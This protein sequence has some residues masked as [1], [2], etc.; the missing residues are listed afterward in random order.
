[1]KT[2]DV[3]GINV[4][5]TDDLNGGGVINH[6]DFVIALKKK[7][8]NRVFDNC[9]E[10]CSGPGFIGFSILATK[11]CNNLTLADKHTPAIESAQLTIAE[12][13]L[14][15]VTTFVSD[16]F[17]NIPC[18]LRFD[19]IVGNP[20][21]YNSSLYLKHHPEWKSIDE[22]I[23]RDTDWNT[24]RTFFKEVKNYL[25]PN[26]KILLVEAVRG[27]SE[28]TFYQMAKDSGLRISDH[29]FSPTR[30]EHSWYL[31]IEHDH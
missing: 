23:Y 5:F 30:P 2:L 24:H 12:N 16:N 29:F 1:M 4:K 19:L 26:G 13:N 21:H 7:Y 8:N 11:I 15:N 3:F 9:M 27:S 14:H 31:E 17:S 6:S 25:A 28:E 18:D 22:R 20:P 10:W